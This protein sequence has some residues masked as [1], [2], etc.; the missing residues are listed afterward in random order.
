[1]S[2]RVH[3]RHRAR[4]DGHHRV[5]TT[6]PPRPVVLRRTAPV[7]AFP[8]WAILGLGV[9]AAALAATAFI[10]D[11]ALT[12]GATMVM[13]GLAGAIVFYRPHIGLLVI[14]TTMLVSY[15]AA[16]KGFGPITINNLLGA[17]LIAILAFQVYRSHDYWFFREPEVRMLLFI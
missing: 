5:T 1:R 7:A 10:S 15:P 2:S 9:A 14:M 16:L 6:S 3:P 17:T 12:I 11:K 13:L 8:L 4:E